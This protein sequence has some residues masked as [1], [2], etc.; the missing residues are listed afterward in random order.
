MSVIEYHPQVISDA[1]LAEVLNAADTGVVSISGIDS[2]DWDHT[3]SGG[4]MQFA[5]GNGWRLG[6]FN[7]CGEWDY[8]EWIESPDGRREEY[9]NR[10][11]GSFTRSH[12]MENWQPTYP[13]RWGRNCPT[14]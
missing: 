5:L 1:E 2:D 12:V 3:Y 7:D 6:I 9:M 10:G 4:I 8:I 11:S 13:W 14:P